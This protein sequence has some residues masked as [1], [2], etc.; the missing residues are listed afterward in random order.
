[1]KSCC[2]IQR[3]HPED[4]LDYTMTK[5]FSSSFKRQN[6]ST[7]HSTVVQTYNPNTKFNKNIINNSLL[8]FHYNLV[9][10]AFERKKPPLATRQA[11]NLQNILIRT[12]FDVIPKPIA[13]PKMLDSLGTYYIATSAL[14]LQGI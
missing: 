5:L 4:A 13:P 14:P 1:M 12:R 10:N 9:K 8:D 2:L 3:G 11:K 6:E 7:Y